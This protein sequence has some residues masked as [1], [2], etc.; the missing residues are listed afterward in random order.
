MVAVGSLLARG[1]LVHNSLCRASETDVCD[2]AADAS[3]RSAV[4]TPHFMPVTPHWLRGEPRTRRNL[5]VMD[6]EVKKMGARLLSV[7]KSSPRLVGPR[8][9]SVRSCL[10]FVELRERG[11]D[12][13]E[14]R[15]QLRSDD[16][17]RGERGDGNQCGQKSVLDCRRARLVFDKVHHDAFP[18][19]F[20]CVVL[21]RDR[22]ADLLWRRSRS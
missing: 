3:D 20:L 10:G 14:G 21:V 13:A 8:R 2:G 19:L 5:R 17:H 18:L 12:L 6:G 16:F 22:A 11:S 9:A 1:C 15:R 7:K 4:K